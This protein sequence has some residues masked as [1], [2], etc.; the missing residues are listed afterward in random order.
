MASSGIGEIEV[1]LENRAFD[2]SLNASSVDSWSLGCGITIEDIDAN[3]QEIRVSDIALS[4]SVVTEDLS[5]DISRTHLDNIDLDV[6]VAV[7]GI[8]SSSTEY[9]VVPYSEI[10]RITSSS[11]E[12]KQE[13]KY[14]SSANASKKIY[15]LIT[16]LQA[17]VEDIEISGGGSGG[18]GGGSGECLWHLDTTTGELFTN[19]QVRIENNLIVKGDSASCGE[20]EIGV[21]GISGIAVNGKTYTD[22]DGDGIIDLG[23]LTDYSLSD[24][25]EIIEGFWY[26]ENG[27]IC[28]DKAVHIKNNLIVDGDSSSSG[29]GE[30]GS[31]GGIDEEELKDYL[32]RN[33]YITSSDLEPYA[34]KT[35]VDNKVKNL[36]LDEYA[37]QRDV[38]ALE[39]WREEVESIIE[40]SDGELIVKGNLVVLGDSASAGDG[41]NPSVEGTVIGVKVGNETYTD[42]EDGILDMTDAFD[43]LDVDVDLSNYYTKSETN[44][45][46]N[47]AVS[48]IDLSNYY[49]KDHIDSMW[50][51]DEDGNIVATKQVK[52]Q[53]NLVV[54]GDTASGGDGENN[55]VE[56]TVTGV[57][58]GDTVYDEVDGGILDMTQAFEGLNVDVDVDLSDYYTKEEIEAKK[59]A[60]ESWVNANGFASDSDLNDL[61]ERVSAA[62]ADIDKLEKA[63]EDFNE[64]KS[65]IDK[66]IEIEET[67]VRI[68]GNLVV[69]G[70]TSSSGE[71]T[72]IPVDGVITGIKVGDEVFAEAEDGILD[73]SDA[74]EG[75]QAEITLD[76]EMSD[77]SEN[78]V[79]NKIIKEYVDMHPRYE[80]VDEVESPDYN[81]NQII[82]DTV[83]SDT[84]VN[85]VQNKVIKSYVDRNVSDLNKSIKEKATQSE[86]N[87][88]N[89]LIATLQETLNSINAWYSKLSNLVVEENG[90]VRIK[91]NLIVDG[92]A[93]SE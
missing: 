74:F 70:D 3:I 22:D 69:D 61:K 2:A 19:R 89:E 67:G 86:V 63:D 44:Q 82:L 33:E 39:D 49:D 80:I 28:T 40:I 55:P 32:D 64:W 45:K 58:V 46:I 52:I 85:G 10:V 57:K 23:N 53:N 29:D 4:G 6:N 36:N 62:E 5:V 11:P 92:D 73:I 48:R 12:V 17:R 42:V 30:S 47:D 27:N 50:T 51:I 9:N 24:R 16:A 75:L 65:D 18:S 56:G 88:L 31:T 72:D 43:G 25:V 41:E 78:A 35:Y 71:G 26:D 84:S 14:A 60:T 77:T 13:K 38:D 68:K 81:P 8:G 1:T 20:G 34:T 90:N 87:E 76:T 93:A 79:Q 59:Y 7:N 37:K 15:D 83:M 66:F 91:S 21:G 54:S